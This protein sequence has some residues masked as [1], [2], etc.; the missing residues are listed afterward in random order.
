M[1]ESP[2][3]LLSSPTSSSVITHFSLEMT[4]IPKTIRSE[5]DILTHFRKTNFAPIKIA[6]FQDRPPGWPKPSLGDE[7]YHMAILTF[8][9][10]EKVRGLVVTE[11]W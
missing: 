2:S 10:K 9:N 1:A 6:L 8:E 5:D 7:N 11:F 3:K 4:R